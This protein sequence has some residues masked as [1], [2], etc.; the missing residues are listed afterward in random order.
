MWEGRDEAKAASSKR[1]LGNDDVRNLRFVFSDGHGRTVNYDDFLDFYAGRERIEQYVPERLRRA[2]LKATKKKRSNKK[3]WGGESSEEDELVNTS[4]LERENE[5]K[6]TKKRKSQ[7]S[8]DRQLRA[9]QRLRE[10]VRSSYPSTFLDRTRNARFDIRTLQF[11]HTRA[12]IV[13]FLISYS[14]LIFPL[15]LLL[16]ALSPFFSFL[17]SIPGTPDVSLPLFPVS[18][19][20]RDLDV[21]F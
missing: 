19:S 1:L 18:L 3:S 11:Q 20:S 14:R 9:L 2:M 21:S 17:V 13:F 8:R 12:R 6:T 16:V 7:G 5:R 10:Q 15:C 4:D